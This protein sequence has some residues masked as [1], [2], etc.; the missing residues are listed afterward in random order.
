MSKYFCSLGL[1]SG[2]SADG[3]DASIIQSD[4][5]IEYRVI[6]DKYFK[7][8]QDIYE[9]IH[10]LKDKINNLRDLNNLSK[11]L[12][13]LENKITLYLV[14]PSDWIIDASIPSI[15][16]PLIRPRL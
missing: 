3:V 15:D 8:G 12:T 6:L 5:D 4:G 9:N 13:S 1:M 10:N 16:V 2:T 14:S 11:E 7:Y